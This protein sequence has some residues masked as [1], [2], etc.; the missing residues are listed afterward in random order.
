MKTKMV[1]DGNVKLARPS[2]VEQL[3]SMG[4]EI[5]KSEATENQPVVEQKVRGRNQKRGK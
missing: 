5:D 3:L 4:W 1:K 2:V